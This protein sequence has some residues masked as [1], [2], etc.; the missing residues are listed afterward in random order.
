M[1]DVLNADEGITRK[2]LDTHLSNRIKNEFKGISIKES[3]AI[4]SMAYFKR[5]ENH[6]IDLLVKYLQENDRKFLAETDNGRLSII[7]NSY[8]KQL[9]DDIEKL[10]LNSDKL[11]E[12]IEREQE[13]WLK[14]QK[15]IIKDELSK[16][17]RN[18]KKEIESFEKSCSKKIFEYTYEKEALVGDG[19]T[20]K[21]ERIN[22]FTSFWE[23]FWSDIAENYK[24]IISV[25]PALPIMGNAVFDDLEIDKSKLNAILNDIRS[26]PIFNNDDDDGTKINDIFKNITIDKIMELGINLSNAI[27][28]LANYSFFKEVKQSLLD[29]KEII[30][31]Q[32]TKKMDISF[33]NL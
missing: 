10:E 14:D 33:S 18:I 19:N 23:S 2:T 16:T 24:E 21:N 25:T 7:I 27:I 20:T 4:S 17:K 15:R 28:L 32:I 22:N 3:F 9:K 26:I 29:V 1:S 12:L 11:K 5:K 30:D 6:G 8:K 13:L 31:K